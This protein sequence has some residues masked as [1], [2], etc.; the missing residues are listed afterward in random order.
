MTDPSDPGPAVPPPP[1]L[2][3]TGAATTS[4]LRAPH[5]QREEGSECADTGNERNRG[6]KGDRIERVDV[7]EQRLQRAVCFAIATRKSERV[8]DCSFLDLSRTARGLRIA[9]F[10]PSVS[11]SVRTTTRG[12]PRR[13]EQG[14]R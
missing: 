1:P 14:S 11:A 9:L 3:L 7:D 5:G 4:G 6:T 13:P 12:R 10:A 8:M 2:A